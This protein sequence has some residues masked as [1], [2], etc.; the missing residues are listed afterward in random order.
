M[1]RILSEPAERTDPKTGLLRAVSRWQI[2]DLSVNDVIGSGFYLLLPVAA[3]Q[4]LG[5]ASVWAIVAAGFGV[6]LLVLCFAEAGSLFDRAGGAIVYTRAAFGDFAGFEV[7]WMSWIARIASIAGLSVFF[8]RAVGFLWEGARGGVG[9]WATIL[10]GLAVLT[11][12][13][14]RGVK[15]GAR[16][17][18]LLTWGKALPL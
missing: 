17:A 11:A 2:V 8:A 9:K 6:L 5:P 14:V 16:T 1:V 4:L 15:S 10:I 12:I 7:G 18:V 3:A 13:N